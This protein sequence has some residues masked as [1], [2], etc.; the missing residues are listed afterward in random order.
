MAPAVYSLELAGGAL[1]RWQGLSP[2]ALCHHDGTVVASDGS[3]LLRLSGATDAGVAIPVRFS[4]PATDGG[5]PGPTR[6]RAVRLSG[7]LGGNLAVEVESDT[8]SRLEGQ[9]GPVGRDGLPGVSVARLGRGHGRSWRLDLIGEDGG[10][11][12]I[13]A[14]EI[15]CTA[16]D[17]REG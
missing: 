12:D 4:L 1:T 8:G 13:G 15:E 9:A 3:R 10:D 14:I 2:M 5:M 6:L 16:L 17:R 7:V 11:L